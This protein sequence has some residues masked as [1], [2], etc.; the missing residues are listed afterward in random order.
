[1]ALPKHTGFG[2]EGVLLALLVILYKDSYDF[3]ETDI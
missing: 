2:V 1:M 3:L